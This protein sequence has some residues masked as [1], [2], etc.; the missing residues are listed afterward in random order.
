[1]VASKERIGEILLREGAIDQDQLF[2]ALEE[3]K[4]TGILTG[5]IFLRLGMVS[6]NV[7]STTLQRQSKGRDIR[8][9]GEVLVE[10]GIVSQAQMDAALEM[11]QRTKQKL[12]TILVK[13]GFVKE[14]VLVK[15]LSERL[16]LQETKLESFNFD[17][18]VMKLLGEE[19]CK[20]LKAIPMAIVAGKLQV[21]M[22]DPTDLRAID[23][24]RFKAGLEIQA[25][26]ATEK[27]LTEAIERVYRKREHFSVG[28]K[29]SLVIS[30]EKMLEAQKLLVEFQ[31]KSLI[32]QRT[33]LA[34]IQEMLLVARKSKAS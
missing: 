26:M 17:P 3:H 2:Y 30:L 5:K 13:K 4:R 21:A 9:L 24:I 28:S 16:S 1:M 14:E 20:V 25:I 15:I 31:E 18:A 29:D 27:E 11:S 23:M 7:L 10:Q 19:D 22:V 12:G 8:K 34:S 33:M 6:E 32:Q